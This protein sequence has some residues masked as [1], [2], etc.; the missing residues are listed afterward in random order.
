[1]ESFPRFASTIST[2][3]IGRLLFSANRL[4][5]VFQPDHHKN[6]KRKVKSRPTLD[7]TTETLSLGVTS[8][9]LLKD[10]RSFYLEVMNYKSSTVANKPTTRGRNTT[11]RKKSVLWLFLLPSMIVLSFGCQEMTQSR[12]ASEALD[13]I[14]PIH[15]QVGGLEY[16]I[17]GGLCSIQTF[18]LS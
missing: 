7:K 6:D 11:G 12:K 1:V 5:D 18:S 2:N 9:N 14:T 4:P 17:R 3:N 10:S 15:K 16:L 13:N 8:S